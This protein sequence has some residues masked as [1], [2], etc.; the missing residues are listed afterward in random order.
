MRYKNILLLIIPLLPVF[1]MAGLAPKMRR[2]ICAGVV[3]FSI[4]EMSPFSPVYFS[5]APRHVVMKDAPDARRFAVGHMGVNWPGGGE[6]VFLAA[7]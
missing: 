7:K 2:L 4:L 3:F 5:Y 1:F 6:E